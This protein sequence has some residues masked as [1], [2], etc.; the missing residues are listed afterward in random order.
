[1]VWLPVGAWPA[2]GSAIRTLITA[3]TP[4]SADRSGL[5]GPHVARLRRASK[6]S[7]I[8]AGPPIQAG[9][10]TGARGCRRRLQLGQVPFWR[11]PQ[12]V[13]FNKVPRS[14]RTLQC[15]L[16]DR[17]CRLVNDDARGR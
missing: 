14:E 17:S 8:L 7:S 3:T 16:P 6:V 10:G 11:K 15:L 12:I 13:V 5:T 4:P 1:C 2:A 9:V